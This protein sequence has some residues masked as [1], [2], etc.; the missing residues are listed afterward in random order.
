MPPAL[1]EP[2]SDMTMGESGEKMAR[3][4]AIRREDQDA[5]AFRSHERAARAWAE[6]VFDDQVMHVYPPPDYQAVVQDNIVRKDARPEDY[7]RLKPAFDKRHGTLTAGNSSPLTDGASALLLMREDK[8]QSLGLPVLGTIV[9]YAFAAIDPLGQMLMGPSYATPRALDRAGLRLADMDLIDMHEAFAA[10]V[11][12]NVRAFESEAFARDKLG[13]R[14][15]IGGIDW[16]KF[17]V[18]GGSI[19]LGHPFAAT[20]GRQILQ[21]LHDLRRRGGRYGLCTACAA[22]GIGAAMILEV[23]Q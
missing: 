4:N 1:K 16:E 8:A 6:G 22:G 9:S 10:Q 11:L 18:S 17:N 12:S 7:A 21:L 19:A 20:G 14:Q 23:A 5:Y 3:E 15:A 13:R 2:S